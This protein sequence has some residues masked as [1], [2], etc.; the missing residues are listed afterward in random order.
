MSTTDNVDTGPADKD[1]RLFFNKTEE[2]SFTFFL[3]PCQERQS[4][5][6]EVEV[7]ACLFV[8]LL[9]HSVGVNSF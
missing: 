4:L 2:R 8:G 3:L 5:V 6:K 1:K 9:A 7:S